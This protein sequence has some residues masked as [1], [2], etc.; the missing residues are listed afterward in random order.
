MLFNSHF[1]FQKPVSDELFA[2]AVD[3]HQFSLYALETAALTCTNT[4]Q[5]IGA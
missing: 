5:T 4:Q 3:L 1:Q 2:L